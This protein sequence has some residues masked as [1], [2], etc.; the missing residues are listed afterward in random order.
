MA[1]IP[2]KKRRPEKMMGLMLRL[3]SSSRECVERVASMATW[4]RTVAKGMMEETTKA[5][6]TP[7][8]ED[9]K[10]G[11]TDSITGTTAEEAMVEDMKDSVIV[12]GSI[13]AEG[14]KANATTVVSRVTWPSIADQSPRMMTEETKP[15]KEKLH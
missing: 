8:V 11:E 15:M 14:S 10:E 6:D 1:K 9:S 3:P 2:K 4:P 12:T 7:N 13:E 5:E